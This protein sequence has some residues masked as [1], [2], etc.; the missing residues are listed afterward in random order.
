MEARA[1]Q[2]GK[3][4]G[5]IDAFE[6]WTWR[7]NLRVPWTEKRTNVSV[8]EEV[9]PRKSLEATILRLK[10]RYFGHVSRA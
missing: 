4:K 8:L 9:K 2:C 5:K 7:R 10:L 6:L 1:G 3:G